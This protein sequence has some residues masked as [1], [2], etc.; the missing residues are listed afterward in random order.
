MTRIETHLIDFIVKQANGLIS[1]SPD[2]DHY[3]EFISNKLSRFLK[4]FRK[5]KSTQTHP[6][7]KIAV[8]TISHINDLI[9]EIIQKY[10][11]GDI[12]SASNI[13][14]DKFMAHPAI[15]SL[16]NKRIIPIDV[17]TVFFR[18]RKSI[19]NCNIS[20]K[21]MFHIPFS[22]RRNINNF[23][24]SING[25]PCLYLAN[26]SYLC[27]EEMNRPNIHEL[28]ISK[29]VYS[30]P[31]SRIQVVSLN[32]K[33]FKKEH[34][35]QEIKTIQSIDKN[36]DAPI[37]YLIYLIT[38]IPLFF[39]LLNRVRDKDKDKDKDAFFKPEYIFPQMFT[40]YVKRKLKFRNV[41]GIEYPSTKII[42]ESCTLFNYTFFSTPPTSPIKTDYCKF[43]S[44]IFSLTDGI[45]LAYSLMHMDIPKTG[46]MPTYVANTIEFGKQSHASYASTIF[47]QHECLL[48]TITTSQL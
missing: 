32:P 41:L 40:N 44:R 34:I 27:W 28:A 38:K 39:I 8:D 11:E 31:Y 24:F 22:K 33:I 36:I 20:T 48:N 17:N 18:A 2:K 35:I 47:Y 14:A 19:I 6:N 26:N 23:R 15:G 13:F 10:E 29:F 30:D 42:D 16:L 45:P 25:Y 4:D 46:F 1:I 21:E 5:L 3:S 9:V 37:F 7:I 12:Y 43:L